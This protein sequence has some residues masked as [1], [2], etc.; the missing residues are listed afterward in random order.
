MN[1]QLK[2]ATQ[3]WNRELGI[4]WL[5]GYR[6][7]VSLYMRYNQTNFHKLTLYNDINLVKNVNILENKT[8]GILSFSGFGLVLFFV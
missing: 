8:L 5:N 6:Q 7:L 4:L 2:K 3:V 1:K